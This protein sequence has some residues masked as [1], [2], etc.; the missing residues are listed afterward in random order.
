M[1]RGLLVCVWFLITGFTLLG[2]S[3]AVVALIYR[4]DTTSV[5][6]VVSGFGVSLVRGIGAPRAF[7]CAGVVR[8]Q[9]DASPSSA[10][11]SGACASVE[12]AGIRCTI[13]ECPET[14]TTRVTVPRATREEGQ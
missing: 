4:S 1:A 3:V 13:R 11:G 6:G 7:L 14:K 9:T 2:V 5:D 12:Q 8:S 10:R